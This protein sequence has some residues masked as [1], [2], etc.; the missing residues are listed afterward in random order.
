MF[1]CQAAK[2][3]CHPFLPS[4]FLLHGAALQW[5]NPGI[6]NGSSGGGKNNNTAF[7]KA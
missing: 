1:C 4:L 7:S 2:L 3:P 5:Q 6:D